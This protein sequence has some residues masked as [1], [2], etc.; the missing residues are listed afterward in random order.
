MESAGGMMGYQDG[1]SNVR[2]LLAAVRSGKDPVAAVLQ[3]A[4]HLKAAEAEAWLER[5]RWGSNP[6]PGAALEA[7]NALGKADALC[8]VLGDQALLAEDMAS[9]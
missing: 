1:P 2:D 4:C 7:A 6:S 3:F 5:A 9:L 8:V